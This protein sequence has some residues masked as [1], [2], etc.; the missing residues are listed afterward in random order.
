MLLH[1]EPEKNRRQRFEA[2]LKLQHDNNGLIEPRKELAILPGMFLPESAMV[3]APSASSISRSVILPTPSVGTSCQPCEG[4]EHAKDHA[5]E[6][7]DSSSSANMT[8]VRKRK[9]KVM[10]KDRKY[11]PRVQQSNRKQWI[12]K[13]L[14]SSE[15]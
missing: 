6:E 8:A 13:E 5:P 3:P 2:L 10:T 11:N 15:Q 14:K 9:T 1:S 12:M 4:N 7:E